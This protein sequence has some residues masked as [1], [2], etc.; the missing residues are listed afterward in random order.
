MTEAEVQELSN[1]ILSIKNHDDNSGFYTEIN[2]IIME[3]V[4]AFFGGQKT[5]EEVAGI[6]QNRATT[7]MN[8]NK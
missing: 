8:E 3:E 6:I 7:Y 4:P 1:Y 5:A 2:R